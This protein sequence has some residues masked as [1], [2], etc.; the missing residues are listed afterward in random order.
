MWY[1]NFMNLKNVFKKEKY[2]HIFAWFL[3]GFVVSFSACLMILSGSKSITSL[4]DVGK[5]YEIQDNIYK[6]AIVRDKGHQES[7]GKAV[8]DQGLYEYGIWIKKNKNQYNY[9]C[10]QLKDL[11][12]ETVEWIIDYKVVK[13]DKIKNS[14]KVFYSL[15]NGM[16][17]ISVPHNS[18]NLIS[19]EIRGENG[20]SFYVEKMQLRETKPIFDA[21]RALKIMLVSYLM[22]LLISVILMLCW[23]KMGIS[24]DIHGWIDVLQE[25][26]IAFAKRFQKTMQRFSLSQGIRNGMITFLFVLMFLYNVWVEISQTYYTRFKYHVVV[27]IFL[28]LAITILSIGSAL[29]KKKWNNTLVWSWLILWTMACASDFLLPKNFRFIGYVMVFVVG[30]FVFVWNNM[31][32]PDALIKN[33]TRAVHIFLFVITVFCLLCRPEVA[34]ESGLR[35]SGISKNPSVFAL[36]LGTVFSVIL[37]EI[38]NSI[39]KNHWIR[40]IFFYILE[41]CIVL[42]F[43]WKAQ[44]VCPLLCMTGISFIWFVRMLWYTKKNNC[45]K[46]LARIVICA[47]ILIIPVYAGLDW[48]VKHIPQVLGISVTFEGEEPIARQ[49]YGMVVYANDLKE[50]FDE[51]RIGQKFN[52]SSLSGILSGRDFYYR[53]YLREMNLFGHKENPEMWGSRRKPHN[54]VLGI[55]HRYGVFTSVPYILMLVMVI[56]RTFRYSKKEVPY[57]AVP[58]YVCLSSIAMSMADNVEQ[59]FVWLPW[60]GLYLMMGIAFDDENVMKA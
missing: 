24:L 43:C 15:H 42:T 46:I 32:K 39:K 27:Y 54:A 19:I 28:L 7:T 4:Y 25:I 36:Y 60:I 57:A 20:S 45:R 34:G 16:N 35:Y 49:Q 1:F 5:V 30:F 31:E 44:S 29:K 53:G 50:K 41:G 59:P 17:V 13:D 26:Y 8:L 3:I 52:M 12:T 2:S 37:G 6:T 33:F 40:N 10:V 14:E 51:S 21:N 9:F 48:G 58:F 47:V 11:S 55:A 56:I 23:S 18:F 22:Y 38:E